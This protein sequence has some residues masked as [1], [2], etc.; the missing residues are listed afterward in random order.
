M[1]IATTIRSSINENPR[2][3]FLAAL[4]GVIEC[5][6]RRRAL[7]KLSK[8]RSVIIKGSYDRH[9]GEANER[10]QRTFTKV[11]KQK[12]SFVGLAL[13]TN[14]GWIILERTISAQ[15]LTYWYA[16]FVYQIGFRQV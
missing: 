14:D 12:L 5:L 8:L 11:T 15:T 2:L 9:S 6:V 13:V 7:L 4:P 10:T 1:L 3:H 16:I